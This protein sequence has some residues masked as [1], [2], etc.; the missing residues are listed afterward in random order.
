MKL[1][2]IIYLFFLYKVYLLNLT[3]LKKLYWDGEIYH[4][5]LFMNQSCL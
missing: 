4:I 3:L 5:S 2:L 1:L